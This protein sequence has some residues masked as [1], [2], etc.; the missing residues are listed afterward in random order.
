MDDAEREQLLGLTRECVFNWCTRD[1]HPMGV[2]MSC[3]WHEGRMW[4]TA[5]AQRHRIAAVRRNSRVSVVVTSTGT[6]LG[7][8]KTVTIKGRCTIHEGS[9]T[10][11]WFYP[12]FSGHLFGGDETAVREFSR[13]L[14]SPL[15]VVL[16]VVPEKFVSYDGQKMFR[17]A[18]GTLEENELAPPLE[19][20]A[21]RLPRERE[22][23][24]L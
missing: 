20:D 10:K 14:D 23:R 12:R 22:R 21:E 1:Q 2:I 24:G 7:P 17:H 13:M 11:E 3:M 5:T 16:E 15:R 19:A 4:L 9:E 18:A 6:K 8:N